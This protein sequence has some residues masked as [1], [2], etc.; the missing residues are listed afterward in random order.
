MVRHGRARLGTE[1]TPLRLLLRNLGNVFEITVLAWSKYATLLSRL[2]L[3]A[4]G[5]CFQRLPASCFFSFARD[6]HSPTATSA[7]SLRPAR[8]GRFPDKFSVSPVI[9]IIQRLLLYSFSLSLAVGA[10]ASTLPTPAVFAVS[11]SVSE[12]VDPSTRSN[13]SSSAFQQ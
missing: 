12:E 10:G 1:K 13:P 4:R 2:R 5:L 3:F 8:P 11:F 9:T 6:F 7:P